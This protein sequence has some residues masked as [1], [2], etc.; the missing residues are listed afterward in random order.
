[1]MHVWQMAV[2]RRAT[3]TL[4]LE[5]AI[6]LVLPAA[7]QTELASSSAACK[8]AVRGVSA[9]A[10]MELPGKVFGEIDDPHSGDRWLLLR[11]PS[12]PGG[13][14]RLV[15]SARPEGAQAGEAGN[16]TRPPE[17]T[18]M[19]RAGDSLIVEEHTAVVDARLEAVALSTASKGAAFEARLMIGG[20][21]IRAVA[22]GRGRAELVPENEAQP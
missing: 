4:L 8:P 5:L 21:T 9:T 10:A 14:G 16:R 13:P 12:H 2:E 7:S 3:A 1:M 6:A 17:V 20:R 15:M 11:N 18:P 22:L 19:I